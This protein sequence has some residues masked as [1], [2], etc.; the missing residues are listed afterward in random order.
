MGTFFSGW[1]PDKSPP[2]NAHTDT[3]DE[4]DVVCWFCDRRGA[5]RAAL[6]AG[7]ILARWAGVCRQGPNPCLA[8]STGICG[9]WLAFGRSLEGAARSCA[10]GQFCNGFCGRD[11]VLRLSLAP[12]HHK[13]TAKAHI[14]DQVARAFSAGDDGR[15]DGFGDFEFLLVRKSSTAEPQQSV[16]IVRTS[17]DARPAEDASQELCEP[18]ILAEEVGVA[19]L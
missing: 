13:L 2:R 9:S 4:L 12:S 7:R 10:S 15:D 17:C 1:S 16:I 8:Q 3:Y 14:I 11:F 6:P 5:S 18:M 19:R